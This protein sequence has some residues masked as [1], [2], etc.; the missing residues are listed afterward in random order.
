MLLSMASG[1]LDVKIDRGRRVHCSSPWS[2]EVVYMASYGV[3]LPRSCEN[4]LSRDTD[5]Q[6]IEAREHARPRI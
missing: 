2:N 3:R 6:G 5:L 1:P 4:T